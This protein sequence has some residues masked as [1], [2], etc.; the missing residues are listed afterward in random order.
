METLGWVQDYSS[1][2]MYSI[3]NRD[4]NY[5]LNYGCVTIGNEM[6]M[7][8]CTMYPFQPGLDRPM[9]QGLLKASAEPSATQL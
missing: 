4:N 5:W 6:M 8:A 2:S 3:Y 1:T 9:T 7:Y